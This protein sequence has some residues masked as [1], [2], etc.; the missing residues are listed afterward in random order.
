M[1]EQQ[2][3][4][5]GTNPA[6]WS[7][8]EQKI[9]EQSLRTYPASTPDRW[10]RIAETLP[11]RSKKDCMKRYKVTTVRILGQPI[12]YHGTPEFRSPMVKT[13]MVLILGWSQL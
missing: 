13:K 2:V 12:Q 9:L 4:Q 10:D 5:T 3:A 11:S 7:A 6:P 8:D 1:A